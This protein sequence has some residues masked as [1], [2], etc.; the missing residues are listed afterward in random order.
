MTG[1]TAEPVSV[2]VPRVEGEPVGICRS[3]HGALPAEVDGRERVATRPESERTAAWG[4]PPLVLRCG[5]GNPPG[6]R[7]TSEIIEVNEVEWFLQES[8]RGYTFTTVGRA[9]HVELHV[10]ASVDRTEATAPLVDVA[11]AVRRHVPRRPLT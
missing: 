8:D 4:D 2:Q 9:A 11:A 1:C 3:L 7:P 6:L 5:V 10:P